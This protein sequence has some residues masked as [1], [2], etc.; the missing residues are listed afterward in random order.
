MISL[1]SLLLTGF[2]PWHQFQHPA[3]QFCEAHVCAWVMEPANAWSSL[4]YSIVGVG[5]WVKCRQETNGLLRLLGPIGILLGLASFAYHAAYT[6]LAQFFDLLSMFCLSH[7]VLVLNFIRSGMLSYR[8]APWLWLGGVLVSALLLE[9]SL[10][11][12]R[13][14]FGMEIAVTILS[15]IYLYFR[16]RA[17]SYQDFWIIILLFLMAFVTWYLDLQKI[18]CHPDQHWLQGHAVWHILTAVY[19]VFIDRFYRQTYSSTIVVP[20][21]PE[22]GIRN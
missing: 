20:T 9:I 2:C 7:L 12:G 19:L 21:S 10:Q 5:L 14:I 15:E 17:A 18:V 3:P 4:A 22:L 11:W 8:N 6:L 16:L 1:S 13:T